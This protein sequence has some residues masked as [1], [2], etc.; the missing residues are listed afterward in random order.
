MLVDVQEQ[1]AVPGQHAA[2][3][4]D[5]GCEEA[6]VVVEGVE[7]GAAALPFCPVP[8]ATES[9]PVTVLVAH[10]LDTGDRLLA[11]RIEGGVDVDQDHRVIGHAAQVFQ[12]V[13]KD[14]RVGL[15]RTSGR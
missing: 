9:R 5:A 12:V 2:C 1:R 14:Y 11:S 10:G 6:N 8:V 15:H 4:F 7:V 3:F 13:G